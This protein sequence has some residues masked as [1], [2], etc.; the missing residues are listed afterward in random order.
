M[1]VDLHNIYGQSYPTRA[2]DSTGKP[3]K[4]IIEVAERY[5]EVDSRFPFTGTVVIY[6]FDGH[7]FHC[8][9][10][11]VPKPPPREMQGLVDVL[12][13]QATF[14]PPDAYAPIYP[15]DGSLSIDPNPLAPNV[16]VKRPSL[17]SFDRYLQRNRPYDIADAVLAEAKVAEIL[18]RN[19]HPNIAE[20]R[21]C[22]VSCD[23]RIIGLCWTE[24]GDSLMRRVNP[25]STGKRIFKFNPDML[26][27]KDRILGKIKAG[28]QHLHRLG[29][30]HN[31]INPA[32]ILLD[33]DDNPVICDFN[34]CTPIGHKLDNVG[35]TYEWYD[36]NVQFA[37]PSNDLDAFEEI[38]EWLRED[39]PK[40]FRFVI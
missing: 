28:I 30:V 7:I 5:D 6:R 3:T 29:L 12:P 16:Y 19:P 26:G 33:K 1:S 24:L 36:E 10:K 23:G 25:Q 15:P 20:Y 18:K 22:E 9:L 31:D 27:D 11:G 17:T 21:G 4:E 8:L 13:M 32:N 39:G 38:C 40:N 35:R 37:D 2:R 34:S 14:I